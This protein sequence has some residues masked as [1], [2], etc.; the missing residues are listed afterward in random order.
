MCY[1]VSHIPYSVKRWRWKTLVNLVNR[2]LVNS[3]KP[4]KVFTFCIFHHV[5]S[6]S[7]R[8]SVNVV[9]CNNVNFEIL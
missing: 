5:I 3:P 2:S 1:V 4:T 9:S 6:R 8:G 7:S